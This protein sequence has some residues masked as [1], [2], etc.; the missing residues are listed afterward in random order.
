MSYHF[1]I[2]GACFL[3]FHW[4]TSNYQIRSLKFELQIKGDWLYED[5]STHCMCRDKSRSGW[6]APPP[7][8]PPP[9]K[10]ITSFRQVCSLHVLFMKKLPHEHCTNNCLNSTSVIPGLTRES[11]SSNKFEAP[12]RPARRIGAQMCVGVVCT[13]TA[14]LGTR[15]V[16][17]ISTNG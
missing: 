13:G 2:E 3:L 11:R 6:P 8:R 10:S 4:P 15:L 7:A 12:L 5:T 16:T 1:S 14:T 9:V 17:L